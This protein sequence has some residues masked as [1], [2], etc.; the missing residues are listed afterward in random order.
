[1]VEQ[2]AEVD[3]PPWLF[4][5]VAVGHSCLPPPE[6]AAFLFASQLQ[7]VAAPVVFLLPKRPFCADSQDLDH[8]VAELLVHA[9]I[10]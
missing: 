7:D 4:R 9:D 10:H 2:R 1:M 8:V 5:E 3:V 6:H